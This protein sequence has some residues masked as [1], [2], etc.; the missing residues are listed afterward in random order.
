MIEAG[1]TRERE[2]VCTG[3]KYFHAR[4]NSFSPCPFV[5]GKPSL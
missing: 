3:E 1:T 2:A 4:A 5:F